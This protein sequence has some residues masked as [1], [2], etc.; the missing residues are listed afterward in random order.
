MGT[1][2]DQ[3]EYHQSQICQLQSQQRRQ[4]REEQI[5]KEKARIAYLRELGKESGFSI[6]WMSEAVPEIIIDDLKYAIT[7][8]WWDDEP[9]ESPDD[10]DSWTKSEIRG[11]ELAEAYRNY[12]AEMSEYDPDA[13]YREERYAYRTLSFW[14]N[15]ISL[16]QALSFT[17]IMDEERTNKA[18]EQLIRASPWFDD[19]DSVASIYAEDARMSWTV[20]DYIGETLYDG[21]YTSQQLGKLYID[22]WERVVA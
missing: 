16:A 12:Y 1:T 2:Q 9:P 8:T 17:V 18:L 6:K 11:P 10:W 4:L 22:I 15:H 3:I 13:I 14:S 20:A 21:A 7:G 19:E 5:E